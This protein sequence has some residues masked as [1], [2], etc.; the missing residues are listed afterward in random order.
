MES[1]VTFEKYLP[2]SSWELALRSAGPKVAPLL[3][4]FCRESL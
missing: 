4:R 3:H 2:E 1:G